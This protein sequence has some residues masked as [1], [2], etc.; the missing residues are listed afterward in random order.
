MRSLKYWAAVLP[1]HFLAVLGGGEWEEWGTAPEVDVIVTEVVTRTIT[2]C[3][4][5][6]LFTCD[7]DLP[8]SATTLD[9]ASETGSTTV[10]ATTTSEG[11]G[12]GSGSS[13]SATTTGTPEQPESTTS[14]FGG[15]WGESSSSS[16]SSSLTTTTTPEQPESTTSGF[17]GGW[18]ESSSSSSSS[19][20]TTTTSLHYGNGTTSSLSGSMSSGISSTISSGT[21]STTT[22]SGISSTITSGS[23]S[24]SASGSISSTISSGTLS[25]TTS[26]GISSTITSGKPSTSAS[27]ST[28]SGISSTI[29]S[30]TVSTTISNGTSSSTSS[31]ISS[32]TSSTI[33]SSTLSSSTSSGNSSTISTSTLS[34]I[35][36]SSSTT[37]SSL[38]QTTSSFS[39]T[40]SCASTQTVSSISQPSCNDASSR[41]QWLCGDKSVDDDTDNLF[42]SGETKQYSLTIHAQDIDFDGTPQPAFAINGKSPGD[43]IVANWGDMV[44]ITVFNGLADNATTIHWH[45]VRQYGTNDQDGVP[46]ITE[47]AIAPGTSRVYKW[48]ASTYGTSWYHS[49]TLAQYGGGIRGPIIIHGPATANYD[50]DMGSVMIHEAFGQTIFQMAYNIARVRGALPPSTNYLLNG[51]NQSPDGTTG[52]NAKWVVKKGKKHL[53]R[54][55]N[56]SA[57]SAYAVHF[58]NHQMTVISADFTPIEPYTTDVLYIQSGQRYNVIVEMDQQPEG[59]YYLR[60]VIQTG[61][62]ETSLNT[63]LGTSNGIF[64]YEGSC[65]TPTSGNFT[66]STAGDCKDEPL[67]S[68]APRVKKDGGSTSAF[69]D[70]VKLLPGGNAGSQ[71]FEGYG[72]VVRWFLGPLGDLAS[73]SATPA[74]SKAINVTFNQPTLKTLATL[75]TLDYNSSLYSNAAVLDGPADEWVY[76]V[77]QNNFQTSHPMHLHGHDFAVLGQGRG[78]FTADM[79]DQLNFDNPIRRDTVLLFGSG[80]PVAFT[81]GWTVIGFPTDNPGAWLMHCH[82]IWHVDGGMGL[83]FLERPDDIDAATYYN[84]AGF[85]DEC[86]AYS[87]YEASGGPLKAPYEA[88]VKRRHVADRAFRAHLH[89]NSIRRF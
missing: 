8:T 2:I 74:A 32:G 44:E 82:I 40:S 78:V 11:S 84:S 23:L 72:S 62:G 57:Q 12:T 24:T 46:G 43:P 25:T 18:G 31:T 14:G 60:A 38:S 16:S 58:D 1:V 66:L 39:T 55:I 29:S 76:F 79:V 27:G 86:S 26:S 15:G 61:C 65:A 33:S 30:G 69:Q 83:Q 28:L 89:G 64:T 68:L 53:F 47:C 67:A 21:L 35:T 36:S 37:T 17:G 51:K 13:G 88:G 5:T 81:S 19:S 20:L 10:V 52:E 75:P 87:S 50:L 73:N 71:T 42:F 59:A 9:S 77:I 7:A 54:I 4:L 41:S 34:T 63:G 48:H 22:S 3:P 49:H 80:T 6:A 70:T 56:S 85:Q 45:G